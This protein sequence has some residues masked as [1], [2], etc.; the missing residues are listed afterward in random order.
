MMRGHE[1]LNQI[2][3]SG[4]VHPETIASIEAAILALDRKVYGTNKPAYDWTEVNRRMIAFVS[5]HGSY[6]K[7]AAATGISSSF[8]HDMHS[9]K[10]PYTD[11]ML[12]ILG[13]RRSTKEYFSPLD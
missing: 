11:Q 9:A 10:R 8:I 1:I 6:R 4:N 5:K 13:L 7:A 3:W 12:A 2:S